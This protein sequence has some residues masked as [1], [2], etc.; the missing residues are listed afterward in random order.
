MT[1]VKLYA[2]NFFVQL[3]PWPP[4][5][6]YSATLKGFIHLSKHRTA[7]NE[8]WVGDQ[9]IPVPITNLRSCPPHTTA[10]TLD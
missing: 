7:T 3:V 1:D 5:I 6:T 4:A 10:V 8:S 2:L 9:L